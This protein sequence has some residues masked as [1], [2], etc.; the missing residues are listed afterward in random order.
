MDTGWLLVLQG[1]GPSLFSLHPEP[2]DSQMEWPSLPTW[3]RRVSGACVRAENQSHSNS[4]FRYRAGLT[5]LGLE[6][7]FVLTGVL[8]SRGSQTHK[9]SDRE[10]R[11]LQCSNNFLVRRGWGRWWFPCRQ[12]S[13]VINREGQRQPLALLGMYHSIGPAWLLPDS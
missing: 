2:C 6:R 3:A 13:R 5:G 4:S 10:H 1:I 12:R 9:T 8:G 7:I 11:H